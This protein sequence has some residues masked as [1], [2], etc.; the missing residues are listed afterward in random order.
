MG[1]QA[2]ITRLALVCLL[3]SCSVALIVTRANHSQQGRSAFEDLETAPQHIGT[4]QD[5]LPGQPYGGQNRAPE[6]GAS[7]RY[8][9]QYDE[10]GRPTN[11][12]SRS[13]ARN[14]IRAQ[15]DVLATVGVCVGTPMPTSRG[16]TNGDQ[17]ISRLNTG[18]DQSVARDGLVGPIFHM[19]D[20]MF[21]MATTWWTTGLR[22]RLQV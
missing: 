19:M 10:R 21:F 6:T 4:V 1:R 18:N 5:S 11:T 2:Y 8:V 17:A 13:M 14:L 3:V 9:Q 12:V 7:Q 15:N 20:L 16:Q 22:H